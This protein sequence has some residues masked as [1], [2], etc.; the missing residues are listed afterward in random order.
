MKLF[1]PSCLATVFVVSSAALPLR[2]NAVESAAEAPQQVN[3]TKFEQ[4]V[5][6]G[7]EF[8]RGQQENDGS[9]S[10]SAG[11]AV[12][13]LCVSAILDNGRSVEDPVVAK[14]L[15]YL[16]KHVHKD[17]GI[18]QD[19]SK[20][21]NYETS[22][23]VLCFVKA[24]TDGRYTKL[25]KNAENFVR[26]RQ[27]N[28]ADGHGPD[29]TS[30][31]GSGYGKHKRPDLSNTSF[32]IEALYSLGNGPDDENMKAALAFVS[33]C[34][35]H[36]SEH[37][38]IGFA[39]KNPDGGFYYTIAAGGSS[40][41]GETANG[42]LRSYGSMTYHGL[43]S[44]IYCGVNKDDARVKAATNWI[45]KNYDLKS[46]PG[47]S[48]NGLYY[49]FH[50]FGKA[51]KALG[52]ESFV[53]AEGVKHNWR[54]ELVEELAKRQTANGSWLNENERWMEGDPNLVTAY[55]LLA[56]AHCRN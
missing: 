36:E 45:R 30:F 26:D 9:F 40:Q 31:G 5:A 18:Y 21:R 13:A 28:L 4:S 41:A 10:K 24:N 29:S 55:A 52:E 27:W 7:I 53:D 23:A 2:V 48:D 42:G 3:N 35:N 43:K 49:Y 6:K 54:A 12:T 51:L 56:L 32:A 15:K 17:G 47:M 16:E 38:T 37:N 19:G 22:I 25:L 1:A 11:P 33:R 44:L 14:G 46:N 50:T 34:Q 39:E 20:Y 8:L